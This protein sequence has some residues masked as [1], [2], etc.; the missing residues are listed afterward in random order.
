MSVEILS[1]VLF[2]VLTGIF[3]TGIFEMLEVYI[4]V[5]YAVDRSLSSGDVVSVRKVGSVLNSRW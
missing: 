2:V 4:T 3:W 1:D 5:D